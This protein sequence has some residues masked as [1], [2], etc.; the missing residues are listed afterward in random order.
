MVVFYVRNVG[1]K[2]CKK[3]LGKADPA[4]RAAFF[5]QFQELFEEVCADRLIL[6]YLDEAHFH[7]DMDLGYTWAPKGEPAWRLSSCLPLSD[8][9]NWYGALDSSSPCNLGDQKR[10]RVEVGEVQ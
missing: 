2:K 10:R 5:A 6:I 7:R 3:L 1:W 4:K 8:R 9:I